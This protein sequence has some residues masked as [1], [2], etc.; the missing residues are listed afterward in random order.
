MLETPVKILPVLVGV[1]A[2]ALA[3][4]AIAGDWTSAT[5][6]ESGLD[7]TKLDALGAAVRHGD[8]KRITGDVNYKISDT[9]APV[10][11]LASRTVSN[12][13]IPSTTCPPLPGTTPAT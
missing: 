8:Y 4:S 3:T 5:P 6:A 11:S 7:P 1:A 10:A 2:M 12:T 9:V 13:G